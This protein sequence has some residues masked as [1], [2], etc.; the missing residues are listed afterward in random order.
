MDFVSVPKATW[1]EL[2]DGL[3]QRLHG[4]LV[5]VEVVGPDWGDQIEAE[6]LPLMGLTYEPE[7][8][9]LYVQTGSD[10]GV[11]DHKIMRPREI[12]VELTAG[13]ISQLVVVDAEGGKQFVRPMVPLELPEASSSAA[14]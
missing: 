14:F 1:R 9:V 8:D 12:F 5:E 13:G 2:F 3:T 7:E 4:Q 6:R 10:A 11:V